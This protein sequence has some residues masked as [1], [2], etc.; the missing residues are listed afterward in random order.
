MNNWRWSTIL[1]RTWF[2]KIDFIWPSRLNKWL[3]NE[4]AKARWFYNDQL[5]SFADW[6]VWFW[7]VLVR[8]IMLRIRVIGFGSDWMSNWRNCWKNIQVGFTN[9]S[10]TFA[11]RIRKYAMDLI[12]CTVVQNQI[13]CWKLK[14]SSNKWCVAVIFILR[15]DCMM[16]TDFKHATKN[17]VVCCII[18]TQLWGGVAEQTL[19]GTSWTRT[20]MHRQRLDCPQLATSPFSIILDD[21]T[22]NGT[23][24]S[25]QFWMYTMYDPNGTKT[26]INGLDR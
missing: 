8:T 16:Q 23:C 11:I 25:C 19:C 5:N 17:V 15:N 21:E 14:R 26:F 13:T 7:I 24:S 20:N 4:P 18:W 2:N 22:W 12:I 1:Q 10:T 9:P 3:H 6:H